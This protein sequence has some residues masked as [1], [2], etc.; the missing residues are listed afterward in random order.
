MGRTSR[1]GLLSTAGK[2][3]LVMILTQVSPEMWKKQDY[4]EKL[5]IWSLGCLIYEVA[6]LKL[7]F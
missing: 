2:N 4:S 1:S 7:P 5:D 6:A 3:Q